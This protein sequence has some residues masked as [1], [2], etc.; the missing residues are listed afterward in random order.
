MLPPE[1][2]MGFE[3]TSTRHS[4]IFNLMY[5]LDVLKAGVPVCL[6]I[7]NGMQRSAGNPVEC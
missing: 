4:W 7:F 2:I 6:W 1:K 3:S 5:I